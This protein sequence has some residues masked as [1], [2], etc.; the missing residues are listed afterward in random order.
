MEENIFQ[1][2]EVSKE[3]DRIVEARIH[4]DHDVLKERNRKLQVEMT[5]VY[6]LPYYLLVDPKTGEK[7]AAW[8]E[9]QT[10]GEV[11]ANWLRKGLARS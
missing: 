4:T 2:P 1:L 9:G 3:L 10:S 5:G 8:G 7:L 6:T 11:F